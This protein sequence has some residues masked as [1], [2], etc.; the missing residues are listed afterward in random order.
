MCKVFNLSEIMY[1]VFLMISLLA[2]AA[3]SRSPGSVDADFFE[4]AAHMR[5]LTPNFC[6]LFLLRPHFSLPS[7]ASVL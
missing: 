4:Y 1:S 2:G 5:R 3:E 6:Q 7:A